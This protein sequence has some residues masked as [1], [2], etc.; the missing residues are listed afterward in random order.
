MC[1]CIKGRR[2]PGS[3]RTCKYKLF[4]IS[5]R[6]IWLDLSKILPFFTFINRA[7][8][9]FVSETSLP[10]ETNM[11][12]SIMDF[13]SIGNINGIQGQA[14][15][16]F[17]INSSHQLHFS[18]MLFSIC[19]PKI[20]LR[21]LKFNHVKLCKPRCD[22]LQCDLFTWGKWNP[23]YIYLGW[24]QVKFPLVKRCSLGQKC[25]VWPQLEKGKNQILK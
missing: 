13:F 20:C 18:N 12:R 6:F 14:D 11:T 15:C 1:A 21:G 19:A 9:N 3:D 4:A 10:R 17:K 5:A 23:R 8:Y 24:T 7:V 25:V 16:S 22:F 2:W